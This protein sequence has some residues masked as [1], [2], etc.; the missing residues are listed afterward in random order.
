MTRRSTPVPHR[1]H[2]PTPPCSTSSSPR[3]GI[4]PSGTPTT[5][6]RLITADSNNGYDQCAA[7]RRPNR[8]GDRRMARLHAEPST[9]TLRTGT[10]RPTAATGRRCIH[11]TCPSA[12]TSEPT[13][14]YDAPQTDNATAPSRSSGPV[15]PSWMV[16]TEAQL[17]LTRPCQT[18]YRDTSRRS[19]DSM[20]FRN[21]GST[22]QSQGID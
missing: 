20:P 21:G 15:S 12:P 22:D 13:A 3:P 18:G 6:S 17:C 16:R 1:P 11:R 19:G 9:R 10:R 5:R 7:Y 8:A 2:R 4:T 14:V